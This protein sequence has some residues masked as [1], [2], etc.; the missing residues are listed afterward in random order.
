MACYLGVWGMSSPTLNQN[1]FLMP[2]LVGGELH[3]VGVLKLFLNQRPLLQYLR[4]MPELAF[5]LN[6]KLSGG[7]T[8]TWK[9]V[10]SHNKSVFIRFANLGIF[11]K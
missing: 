11:D 6:S 8:A 7:F 10:N 2:R 4:K 1:S 9:T 5:S 3:L